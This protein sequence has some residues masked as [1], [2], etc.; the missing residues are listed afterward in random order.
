MNSP[1]SHRQGVSQERSR[2]HRQP[3]G[4]GGTGS[5][6]PSDDGAGP[7]AGR[8]EPARPP[9]TVPVRPPAPSTRGTTQPRRAPRRPR[10]VHTR[11]GEIIQA[12]LRHSCAPRRPGALLFAWLASPSQVAARRQVRGSFA[13]DILVTVRLDRVMFSR[14]FGRAGVAASRSR[15]GVKRAA[16]S[17][18]SPRAG[19]AG[20]TPD[21]HCR[22]PKR[23]P[24]PFLRALCP[25]CLEYERD[26]M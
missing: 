5:C 17:W 8:S 1:A 18:A 22:V 12:Q 11:I 23:C 15:V 14:W 6:C 4:Q 26:A 10:E 21:C 24:F 13:R 7:D 3:R 25:L 19:L 9:C 20:L 2:D 16:C